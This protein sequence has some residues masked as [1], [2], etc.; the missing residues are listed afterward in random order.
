MEAEA[1]VRRGVRLRDGGL[2]GGDGGRACT[3]EAEAIQEPSCAGGAT[4]E[5]MAGA[6]GCCSGGPRKAM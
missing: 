5:T 6:A 2:Y 4:R 1:E 3:V